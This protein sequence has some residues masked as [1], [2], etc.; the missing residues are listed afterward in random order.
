MHFHFLF[1]LNQTNLENWYGRNPSKDQPLKLNCI[2]HSSAIGSVL[3]LRK[4]FM[5]DWTP[6]QVFRNLMTSKRLVLYIE[7]VTKEVKIVY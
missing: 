4:V 2:K 1:K 5:E 6:G 3:S 7:K